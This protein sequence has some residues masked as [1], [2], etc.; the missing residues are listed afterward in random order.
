MSWF[1][2]M[3]G[4]L[5]SNGANVELEGA[6]NFTGGLRATRN[7][8]E[9]QADISIDGD[10]TAL[11][12]LTY[13][14]PFV[15]P[16][17]HG[18]LTA[19]SIG[20]AA[21]N[22]ATINTAIVAANAASVA[23]TGPVEVLLPAGKFYISTTL[24]VLSNTTLRGAGMGKTTIYMPAD[25]FDNDTMGAYDTSSVAISALG[26]IVS[27]YTPA[28]NITLEDFTIESEISDGRCLYPISMRNVLN[29]NVRRVEIFGVP[30]G[31]LI[32]FDSVIGGE[33][34]G[35]YLHDC[36]TAVDTYTGDAQTTGIQTDDN[37]VDLVASKGLHIHHNHIEDITMSGDALP[38]AN[39]QTDGIQL[40]QSVDPP[41][42]GHDIHDNYIRNVGEGIDCFSS[43]C[44]IHSNQLVDCYNVGVKL[45]HGARR[46]HVYG[47]T[48]MRPG[49]AGLY[50]GGSNYTND[51]VTGA[52][53]DNYLHD[54]LIHGVNSS[55]VWTAAGNAAIRIDVDGQTYKPN[56]NTFRKNKVTGGASSMKHVIHQDNGTN[57]WYDENEADGY[58]TAY[59]AVLGG[60]ARIADAKK[61]LVR[62]GMDPG[63]EIGAGAEETVI[64]NIEE[65]D[66]RGEYDHTTGVFT[67]K[68]PC[69]IEVNAV[70][71]VQSTDPGDLWIL[72]IRKEGVTRME[73]QWYGLDNN[74]ALSVDDVFSLDVGET[75][76]VRIY[77][78]VGTRDVGGSVV[79]TRLTV[80]EVPGGAL[81]AA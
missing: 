32:A 22:A 69:T 67:A 48:I 30:T 76:D 45:I 26:E 80:K 29:G 61:A 7:A 40:G 24:T 5:R 51:G 65:L 33:I 34:T 15:D 13:G 19:N 49:L 42:H 50:M 81:I 21:A 39:M 78:N 20:A 2:A 25:S 57:N 60:T 74:A 16:R 72:R 56:N 46:N 35:C 9:G 71:L 66:T 75:F 4:R 36:T 77:E 28:E 1:E 43:E 41:E 44:H 12:Q 11:T 63:Q 17:D 18:T 52:V 8:A 37:R 6:I 54:N 53:E 64:F 10:P 31:S 38:S 73:R 55:G 70:V 23:M 68:S 59:S 62:A 14:P 58:A 27:D 79:L 47:N 3:F